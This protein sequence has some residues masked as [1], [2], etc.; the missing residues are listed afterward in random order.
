MNH[1]IAAKLQRL[2]DALT[3]PQTLAFLPALCLGAYW[4]GGEKLLVLCALL[5]PALMASLSVLTSFITPRAASHQQPRDGLTKLPLRMAVV[6]ALDQTLDS[7]DV[8]GRTTACLVIEIDDFRSI[9]GNFGSAA[10]DDILAGAARRLE[11]VLREHDTIARLDNARFAVALAPMRRA[12]LETMIQMASRIQAILSE[13]YSV[14]ATKVFTTC[15]IG[16]CMPNRAPAASGQAFLDAAEIALAD[17]HRNGPGAIRAYSPSLPPRTLE[18]GSIN[19]DV[20][21]ALE[22]GQIIPWFQPQLSTDTGEVSGMEALA[23]W[24]HPEK[25]TLGPS[26]FLTEIEELGLL[27][28]LHEIILYHALMAVKTWDK[29]GFNV[30]SVAVNFSPTDLANPKI[31]DK[32]RWELDR[33]E[34]EP[35]RLSVEILESVISSSDNDTISRNIW[36]LKEMG[37]GIDLDD[38]GTGH[39]SIANIRRFAVKRIKIDRSYVSR[40]DLDRDQQ[41]MLAAILTMAERLDLETLAEGVETVGEHAMLS[42][43]GCGHV[44]GFSISRPM[45]F[46]DTLEWMDAHKRKLAQTPQIGRRAS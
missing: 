10:G 2:R 1:D 20:G 41:S 3:G 44:Q 8:T 26:Q 33:F 40:C 31:V 17:A 14:D 46:S 23:R 15:S 18:R 43:L 7:R 30:P 12:D 29:A 32:I 34:L 38:Y 21:E 39:A 37:C 6:E 16:F 19:A 22:S 5:L 24:D 11:D 35:S 4:F 13:P 42:Q 28:R 27:E 36:A 9:C 25:G 45:A